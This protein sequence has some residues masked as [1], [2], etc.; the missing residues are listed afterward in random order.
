MK[1]LKVIE[2][3]YVVQKKYFGYLWH[4]SYYKFM[5]RT[6]I[7]MDQMNSERTFMY[8]YVLVLSVT[9]TIVPV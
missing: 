1:N 4:K 7:Y 5:S 6:L 3:Y 9:S 8:R 2:L